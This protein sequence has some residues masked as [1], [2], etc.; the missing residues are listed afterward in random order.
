MP[1]PGHHWGEMGGPLRYVA[2]YTRSLDQDVRITGVI[3]GFETSC[4]SRQA[5]KIAETR[6]LNYLPSTAQTY[7]ENALSRT[8]SLSTTQS[9]CVITTSDD[10][11]RC[12][13]SCRVS[14][15]SKCGELRRACAIHN[16]LSQLTG[17]RS[18]CGKRRSE[19][20]SFLQPVNM[21][22][23]TSGQLPLKAKQAEP[24]GIT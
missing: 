5:V 11:R 13:L 24:C 1:P 9:T 21:L 12:C 19:P 3:E 23:A 15:S 6:L 10:S 4:P 18:R 2:L 8:P 20:M 14:L 16:G 7:M 17:K 22:Q